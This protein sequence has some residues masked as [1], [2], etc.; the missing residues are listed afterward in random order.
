MGAGDLQ[1]VQDADEGA[2]QEHERH[3]GDDVDLQHPREVGIMGLAQR[4]V[5]A[6]H[7][8]IV[9]EGTRPSYDGSHMGRGYT[10]WVMGAGSPTPAGVGAGDS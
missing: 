6:W 2:G 9:G 8:A 7:D 10:V 5:A 3:P 1:Q 4:T